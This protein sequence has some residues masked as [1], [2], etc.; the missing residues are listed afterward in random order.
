MLSECVAYVDGEAEIVKFKIIIGRQVY[1]A[2][3][4]A[5]ANIE[6]SLKFNSD[7]RQYETKVETFEF[8]TKLY[9]F[10]TFIMLTIFITFKFVLTM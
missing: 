7:T 6:G 10:V 9:I 5:N 3:F 1:Q 8:I 4:V 2:Y